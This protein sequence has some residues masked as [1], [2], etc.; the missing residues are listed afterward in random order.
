MGITLE[1]KN[2]VL[3]TRKHYAVS[4]KEL[5]TNLEKSVKFLIQDGQHRAAWE[6]GNSWDLALRTVFL[7]DGQE[8]DDDL[9]RRLQ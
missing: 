4:S 8:L 6:M 7:H 1:Q 5:N 2:S 9:G 3:P